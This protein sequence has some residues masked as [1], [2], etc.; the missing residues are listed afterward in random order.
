MLK[1]INK[2]TGQDMNAVAKIFVFCVVPLTVSEGF[3]LRNPVVTGLSFIAGSLLQA[4]IPPRRRGLLVM[5][6]LS[7]AYTAIAL[8]WR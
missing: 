4:L 8:L 1:Q 6:I 2:E 5:L 7:A 3:H